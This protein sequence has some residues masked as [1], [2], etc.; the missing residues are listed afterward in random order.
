MAQTQARVYTAEQ[1]AAIAPPGAARYVRLYSDGC[2]VVE[3]REPGTR[4][5]GGRVYHTCVTTQQ[6]YD[7]D[8]NP[9]KPPLEHEHGTGPGRAVCQWRDEPEAGIWAHPLRGDHAG[10]VEVRIHGF[11]FVLSREEARELHTA[12]GAEL[13]C[14]EECPCYEAGFL[15]AQDTVGDWYRP[16]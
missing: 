12:L 3:Y 9:I 15:T 16:W 11:R 2:R 6:W 4:N 5:I 14:D 8:G 13:D 10:R 1:L 7:A